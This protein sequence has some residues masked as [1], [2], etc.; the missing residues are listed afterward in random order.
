MVC[1]NNFLHGLSPQKPRLRIDPDGP[2]ISAVTDDL[3]RRVVQ[4]LKEEKATRKMSERDLA[5]ILQWSQS[6]IT[7]K[8]GGR[9]PITLQELEALCFALGLQPTEVVRDRGYEFCA[10]LTPSELRFLERLRRLPRP[11]VDSL[12]VLLKVPESGEEGPRKK[13]AIGKPRPR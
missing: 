5:G 12:M 6:K 9:T 8:L 1:E 2:M 3:A 13:P 4:R 10:E 7:Q 11:V